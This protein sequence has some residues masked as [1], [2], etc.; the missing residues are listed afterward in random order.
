VELA[1]LTS[2]LGHILN[3]LSSVE[4]VNVLIILKV[5]SARDLFKVYLTITCKL[6]VVLVSQSVE[7]LFL[8]HLTLLTDDAR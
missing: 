3:T 1:V 5:N 8:C 2:V 4:F 7:M 6:Y